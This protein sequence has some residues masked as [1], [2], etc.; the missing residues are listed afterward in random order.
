MAFNPEQFL[1]A[2]F[3]PPEGQTL[4]TTK[5][6][7]IKTRVKVKHWKLHQVSR[8]YGLTSNDIADLI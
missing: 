4:T 2:A 3:Q 8:L 5:N 6:P 7:F 1:R